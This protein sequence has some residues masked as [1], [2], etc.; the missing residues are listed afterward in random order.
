MNPC[1]L[2]A[3]VTAIANMIACRL[4]DNELSLISS[5]LVQL[6][7][8]LAV[9]AAQRSLFCNNDTMTEDSNTSD[10]KQ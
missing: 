1:E 2:T 9:I 3:S 6:G 4:D 5:V 7:D 8:T 10:H